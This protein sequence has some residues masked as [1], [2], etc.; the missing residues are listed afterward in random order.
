M[1]IWLGNSDCTMIL[2][3][4]NRLTLNSKYWLVLWTIK[5]KDKIYKF[6]ILKDENLIN[7]D[8]NFETDYRTIRILFLNL[9]LNPEDNDSMEMVD[10]IYSNIII[11]EFLDVY[12]YNYF[13]SEKVEQ[14]T[15]T[16]K[17]K[18]DNLKKPEIKSI[19][20]REFS[21]IEEITNNKFIV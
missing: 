12:V 20:Y 17:R 4:N 21:E 1:F 8:G 19:R 15:K 10:D 18:N 7:L 14:F 6:Y 9:F 2:D 13:N 11:G 5:K 16:W 3:K